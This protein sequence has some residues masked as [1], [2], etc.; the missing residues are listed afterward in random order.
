LVGFTFYAIPQFHLG[1]GALMLLVR[2]RFLV[3]MLP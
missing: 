2:L 1:E 3:Q